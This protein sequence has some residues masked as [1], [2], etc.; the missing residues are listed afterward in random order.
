MTE[1]IHPYEGD[2]SCLFCGH[3]GLNWT[4]HSRECTYPKKP[5]RPL[6]TV[7]EIRRIWWAEHTYRTITE[8]AMWADNTVRIARYVA[9][10]DLHK[11]VEMGGMSI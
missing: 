11:M 2:S 5:H 7:E 10:N 8:E 4:Y 1:E 6:L 9:L 3:V